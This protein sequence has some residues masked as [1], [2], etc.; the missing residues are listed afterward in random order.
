MSDPNTTIVLSSREA[1]DNLVN[2]L[3]PDHWELVYRTPVA[4]ISERLASRARELGCQR[5]DVAPE[6][7][8]QGLCSAVIRLANSS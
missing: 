5:V 3:G 8:D 6:A 1:L 7:S 2:L 4:V